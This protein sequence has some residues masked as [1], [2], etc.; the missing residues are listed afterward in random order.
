MRI[1]SGGLVTGAAVAATILTSPGAMADPNIPEAVAGVRVYLSVP[2]RASGDEHSK[3]VAPR[4]GMQ[5]FGSLNL[6]DQPL[7]LHLSEQMPLVDFGLTTQG[8]GKFDFM[9]ADVLDAYEDSDGKLDLVGT[10][11]SSL[12]TTGVL[13]VAIPVGAAIYCDATECLE[14]FRDKAEAEVRTRLTTTI[15]D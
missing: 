4:L 12:I 5:L 14:Q 1:S 2:F 3:R 10:L 15:G 6:D 11:A 13:L 8:I 7:D 9:G